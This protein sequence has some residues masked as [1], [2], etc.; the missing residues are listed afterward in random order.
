MFTGTLIEA[1]VL[2]KADNDHKGFV[3]GS[4]LGLHVQ[5]NV[6]DWS[7]AKQTP[8]FGAFELDDRGELIIGLTGE[9]PTETGFLTAITQSPDEGSIHLR[10]NPP[11]FTLL[12]G[13]TLRVSVEVYNLGD[14]PGSIQMT[15]RGLPEDWAKLSM[16]IVQLDPGRQKKVT[17]TLNPPRLPQAKAGERI[18]TIHAVS[19]Q[20][21]Q[22]STEIEG[23]MELASYTQFVSSLEP[24]PL[25]AGQ[26]C[27]IT[28]ENSG[29]QPE[30][31]QVEFID[32]SEALVF[33]PANADVQVREGQTRVIAFNA[34]PKS[35]RLFGGIEE[36]D[37]SVQISHPKTTPHLH[38]VELLC[39]PLI[40]NRLVIIL[41][42]IVFVAV[43]GGLLAKFLP[44]NP[45]SSGQNPPNA[46]QTFLYSDP[47]GDG[48]SNFDEQRLRTDPND[49]DTDGDGISDFDDPQ[50]LIA[51]VVPE[52]PTHTS[53]ISPTPSPSPTSGSPTLTSPT[54]TSGTPT[55]TFTHT[56]TPTLTPDIPETPLGGSGFLGIEFNE[57][58][59]TVTLDEPVETSKHKMATTLSS[60]TSQSKYS[61]F[62]IS[63]DG[64]KIAFWLRAGPGIGTLFVLESN[65]RARQVGEAISGSMAWDISSKTL[66]YVCRGT[67]GDPGFALAN[68]AICI[69]TT[70]GGQPSFILDSSDFNETHTITTL[71]WS[72]DSRQVA[73][74]SDFQGENLNIYT[75]SVS[76][77]SRLLPATRS[78]KPVQITHDQEDAAFPSFSPDGEWIVYSLRD[79]GGDFEIYLISTLGTNKSAA[80]TN[81]AV[82]DC[83]SEWSPDGKWL[84][85]TSRS[86]GIDSAVDPSGIV[87]LI[88]SNG[89]TAPKEI[90]PGAKPVWLPA[91]E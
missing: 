8:D 4:E 21:S 87:M 31:F 19:L 22:Q 44:R 68:P 84:A 47:D 12:P 49:P 78:I 64:Q 41:A 89:G 85:Y 69:V 32:P 13:S 91:G 60:W 61:E 34:A 56:P 30:T 71:A 35:K 11:Q 73:F 24:N 74:A 83:W 26:E 52:T 45:P 63:P 66:A 67:K 65:G 9:L 27:E 57:L 36:Y 16:N 25:A 18:F 53:T 48:L 77:L 40:S 2:G 14:R 79:D 81:N 15:L 88:P 17:L 10:L 1:L 7:K 37:F 76:V 23:R 55:A 51:A 86:C 6:A 75:V 3:T 29:N 54:P 46:T 38:K 39:G 59:Y 20:D 72:P 62:R 70:A 80:L 90:T 58:P 50:P 5:K 28:I 82:D 42:L 33:E 43:V